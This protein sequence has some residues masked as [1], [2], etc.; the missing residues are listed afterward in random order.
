MV[1]GFK[2]I[3]PVILFDQRGAQFDGKKGHGDTEDPIAQ[4]FQPAGGHMKNMLVITHSSKLKK[5][6]PVK[7]SIQ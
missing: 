6:P 2:K 4:C 1:E 5:N 3:I 7:K